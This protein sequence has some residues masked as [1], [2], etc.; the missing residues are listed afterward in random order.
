VRLRL[1][2]AAAVAVTVAVNLTSLPVAFIAVT[3]ALDAAAANTLRGRSL[4]P[5]EP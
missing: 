2:L 1:W 3:V 4:D 5:A